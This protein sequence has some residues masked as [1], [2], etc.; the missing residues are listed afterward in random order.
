MALVVVNQSDGREAK[1][2]EQVDANAQSGK[3]E[4]QYNPA[5]AVWLVSVVFPLK[6]EPEHQ[7]GEHGR[8]GVNLAFLS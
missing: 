7:G 6:D 1:K 8:V 3:I 2:V 5:V 4:N